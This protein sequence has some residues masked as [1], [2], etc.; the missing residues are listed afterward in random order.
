VAGAGPRRDGV[1]NSVLHYRLQ[2][3]VR[4]LGGKRRRFYVEL[5]GQP[6]LEAHLLDVQVTAQELHL[7][8]ERDELALGVFEREP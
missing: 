7:L 3:Q 5:D 6:V 2:Y 4:R 8:G 1:P